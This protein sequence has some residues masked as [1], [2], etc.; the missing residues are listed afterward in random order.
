MN[1]CLVAIHYIK[2]IQSELDILNHDARLLFDLKISPN[3]VKEELSTLKNTVSK[4]SDKNLYIEGTIWYQPTLFA[5]I[6]RNLGV[7]DDWLNDL[8]GFLAVTY[9]T[10]IYKVLYESGRHSYALII[11]LLNQLELIISDIKASR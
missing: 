2:L 4:L 3:L 7:V 6:D 8:D 5:I 1:Q 9:S 11:G 10:T